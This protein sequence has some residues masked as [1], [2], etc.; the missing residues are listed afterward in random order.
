MP[1]SN[2]SA[3]SVAS[4]DAGGMLRHPPFAICSQKLPIGR[5]TKALNPGGAGAKPPQAASAPKLPSEAR[6]PSYNAFK[7]HN[8]VSVTRKRPFMTGENREAAY[9]LLCADSR[10]AFAAINQSFNVPTL[11]SFARPLTRPCQ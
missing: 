5:G 8:L 2:P 1:G 11:Q 7:V 9:E 3:D 10:P 6:A 4:T